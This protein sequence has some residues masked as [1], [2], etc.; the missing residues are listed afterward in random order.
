MTDFFDTAMFYGYKQNLPLLDWYR[1][2]ED[3][4]AWNDIVDHSHLALGDTTRLVMSWL[5]KHDMTP[6][7][8][9]FTGAAWPGVF[10]TKV[11][12]PQ[13][14]QACLPS[15]PYLG[16]PRFRRLPLPGPPRRRT[17]ASLNTNPVPFP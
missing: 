15:H 7:V 16:H 9:D 4:V 11:F 8:F 1:N 13:L 5:L 17:Y 3:V 6:I 10:V 12:V 14:T 2:T